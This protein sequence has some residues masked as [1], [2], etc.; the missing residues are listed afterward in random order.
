M[1]ITRR[2]LYLRVTQELTDHRQAFA[3][4][5]RTGSESVSVIPKPE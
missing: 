3:E 2:W 4:R 1:R 5:Q